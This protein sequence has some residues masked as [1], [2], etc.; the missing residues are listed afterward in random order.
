MNFDYLRVDL[1]FFKND[2]IKNKNLCNKICLEIKFLF[3]QMKRRW[4]FSN[5]EIIPLL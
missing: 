5:L 2:D 3:N 1:N 4:L